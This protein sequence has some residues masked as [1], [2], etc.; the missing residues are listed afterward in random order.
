MMNNAIGE[1]EFPVA[2]YRAINDIERTEQPPAPSINRKI[3]L[4][5]YAIYQADDQTTNAICN[6]WSVKRF[7]KLC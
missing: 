3:L 6:A 1:K 4:R 2:T 7:V 5:P